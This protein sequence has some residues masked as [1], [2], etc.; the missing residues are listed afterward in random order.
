MS[1]GSVIG[2]IVSLKNNKRSRKRKIGVLPGESLLDEGV[3]SHVTPTKEELEQLRTRLQKEHK[4]R[5]V[6]IVAFFFVFFVIFCFGLLNIL[7]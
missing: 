5:Q 3:K 2:A 1:F 6:K 7:F 4:Q